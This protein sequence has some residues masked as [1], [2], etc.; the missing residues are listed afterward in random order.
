[1]AISIRDYQPRD[2]AVCRV[3]WA[4][5][6]DHHRQ[7]YEDPTIGGD[8]PGHGFDD[9]LALPARLAS[10]V[11]EVDGSVVGLSGLL[12]RGHRAEI[13]PVVVSLTH[14]GVG[15]GR[16][17]INRVVDEAESRGFDYVSIRPVARNFSAIRSFY[18]AGFQTLG[19]RIEL[20]R[21]LTQRKHEWIEGVSLQG[22]DFRF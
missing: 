13:E 14:R 15:V 2:V 6:T 5:L 11:A 1:M 3:L 12:S 10:W 18:R 19:G 21:D 16:L 7:L 4:E 22:R 9:Y 17:L 8:D 20:T